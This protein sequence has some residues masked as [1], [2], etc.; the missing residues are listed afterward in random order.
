VD[1]RRSTGQEH[2][3]GGGGGTVIGDDDGRLEL[4]ET[5]CAQGMPYRTFPCRPCPIVAANKA[6]PAAKFPAERW[7]SLTET[8]PNGH[9]G[10]S[11]PMDAPKFSCHKGAPGTG[12]ALACAGWL[13]VFGLDHIDVRLAVHQNQLP[14][15]VFTPGPNWPELHRSWAEV[16]EHQTWQPGD[17]DDHLDDR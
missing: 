12:T 7:D 16:R 13:A 15:T 11:V 8:V 2:G 9:G 14:A 4:V 3:A 17:P 6:N 1:P 5:T 10:A